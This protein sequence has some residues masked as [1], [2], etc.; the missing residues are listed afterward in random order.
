MG[1]KHTV[2]VMLAVAWAVSL[3]GETVNA[4]GARPSRA[5]G[6]AWA[7]TAIATVRAQLNA[8]GMSLPQAN[9]LA[10][11]I[12]SH[13]AIET[14]WGGSQVYRDSRNPA[15]VRA[16]SGEGAV[17]VGASGA[18]YRSWPSLDAATRDVLALYQGGAYARAWGELVSDL[19]SAGTI[20][21]LRAASERWYRAI[22][23]A[24]W[25]GPGGI[26]DYP[27]VWSRVAEL[28]TGA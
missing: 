9:R 18:R 8:S 4:S 22:V 28:V 2:G 6:D 21:A 7:R 1:A 20:D 26:A 17:V 10:T 16:T 23:S 5:D 14:G 27:G 11:A 19:E 25:S 12:V 15:G 13:W 24:G 3:M